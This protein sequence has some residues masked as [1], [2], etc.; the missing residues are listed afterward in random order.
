MRTNTLLWLFLIPF[1]LINYS[2]IIFPA[3]G[4]FLGHQCSML[5]HL[6]NN[7]IFNP[8]VSKK[9]ILWNQSED[10]CQ[11]PGVTCNEGRVIALDLSEES[12]SEGLVNS[13]ILFNLQ[14][15]Q[16]LNLAFNNLSSVIPSELYKL[17]DLRYLNLSSAGFEG[18]IPHE[19]SQLRRLVTLD[20]SSSFSS[21]HR[22]K[23]EKPNLEM[24]LLPNLT[25]IT[26]LYLDGVAISAKGQQWYHALSSL[27]KLR[28][29][30][31]SSCNLS[32]PVD[33]SFA[34]LQ[35]LTVLNLSHN[36]MSSTVPESF[37]K[38]SKL[39]QLQLRSCGLNG[40]FPKDIFQIPAL[41]ILDISDNKGLRGSLPNFRSHGSLYDMNL[42]NT[43]F[44]GML[45]G[46]ISNLKQLSRIDLS[47]CQFNG[48]LPSSISELTQLVY[49]DLSYNNFIGSL[50]S[51][52]M[53]KN[54]TYLSLYHNHLAGVLSPNHFEV[55]KN[56]V[57]I[58]LGFNFFSGKLPSSLLKLP[59]LRELKVPFNQFNGSLDEFVIASPLLE[60]LDLGNNN[61]HGT[62]PASI[63]NTT[64]LRL[65]QLN[66]NKLNGTI[67]LDKIRKLGNL[68]SLGLSGNNLSVDTYYRD[69][70]DLSNYPNLRILMLS[71]CKLR[72]IPSFLRNQSTLLRLDLADNEIE[73]SIPHWIW[74]NEY[75]S[76]FNLSKNFLT[77]FEGSF[78]NLSSNLLL[79]DLSFNQLQGSIPFIPTLANCLDYSNNRFNSVIPLD[80]GNR[81]PF[82]NLLSFSNNS[83]QGQIPESFCNASSLHLLDLSHNNLVGT[84]PKCFAMMS[85][86]RVLNFGANKLRG[87]IPNS[88][89]TSCNLK[90]LDLN[91]NLLE[92][93]I[94]K[95]LAHCQNLQVLNLRKNSLT[96]RFPCFLSNIST[97]RIM[98][99]GLNK[100]HGSI[101]C[102]RS[103]GDWKMLH[104]VDL[105]SNNFHGAIPGALLN[106]W[107]A[108]MRDDN[109][110]S[111][112]GHL[113]IDLYDH[114][115]PKN[116]QDLLS[117]VDK[118]LLTRITKLFTNVSRSILDQSSTESYNAVDISRLQNSITITNKGKQMELVRIQKIFTYLDMS[119]NNFEGPIPNELMQFKALNALNLSNN[120]LSG[121]IPSSISN[122]KNLESLDLSENYFDG[123]IPTELASLSF[124]AYLN[125]SFNHL[126]GEIPKGTQIQ[127]FDA[128]SFEGNEE[129]CGV[130]LIHS[131]SNDEGTSPETPIAHSHSE[132]SIDW[133]ILSAEL[134]C[135]FGFGIFILP[136]IFS[137]RWKLWYSEHVDEMLHR[138]IPQ[139]EFVYEHSGE[140]RYK[141]LRWKN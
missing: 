31:M 46:A 136:L 50:P 48:T 135:I 9:F 83:F 124:L 86:L 133:N 39:V 7:L 35:S 102:P 45:P 81:L 32:G 87:Y 85:S 112:F 72:E 130:P 89:P 103:S 109:G 99:L 58:D 116:F 90:L 80:I 68:T 113:F 42:S 20:L 8:A 40:S 54:L 107:K 43:N 51:F 94:P 115:D 33:S 44:S 97:L 91:E 101:R 5:L 139:L 117:S 78:W 129:L 75:L 49:L 70:H 125:L 138:I 105:A 67:Q 123:L 21:S 84:I 18:Q 95:S 55:H 69:V 96:D 98:D 126:V 76:H 140:N 104:I 128:D 23:L 28:V 38:L 66:G 92:G 82:I 4:Y 121:H 15:L 19:I 25:N 131:C 79:L 2:A 11:W 114:Y 17:S 61:I 110:V 41:R 36:N 30:S 100:L 1:Y 26:E 93:T 73:G 65:I 108:M 29:L 60:M 27:P 56:L 119:S 57:S 137:R 111:E 53:S 132:R 120:A 3:Y 59:C 34:K 47:S 74:E 52:N 62:I 106:S 37:A 16:S 12:I 71:S 134:G 88:V 77:S 118:S 14:Y 22:L 127:S 10:C 122:L 64:T 6:K 13:S 24:L 63:F 141:T